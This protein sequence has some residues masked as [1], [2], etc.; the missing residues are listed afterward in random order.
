MKELYV[1]QINTNRKKGTQ[2]DL[3]KEVLSLLEFAPIEFELESE[4]DCTEYYKVINEQQF[5]FETGEEARVF[6]I[7]ILRTGAIFFCQLKK[8]KV[9]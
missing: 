7:N 2:I 9:K 3:R 1:F 5:V 4:N 8:V 6:A